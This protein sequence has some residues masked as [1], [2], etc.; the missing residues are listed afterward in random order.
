M[1]ICYNKEV[2]HEKKCSCDK[3]PCLQVRYH[4]DEIFEKTQNPLMVHKGIVAPQKCKFTYILSIQS[5]SLGFDVVL[6]PIDF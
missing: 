2:S 6:D 4:L 3:E 5:K 1:C